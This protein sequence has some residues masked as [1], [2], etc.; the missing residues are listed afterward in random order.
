MAARPAVRKVSADFAGAKAAAE[1]LLSKFGLTEPPVDPV[2]MARQ[3]G[4]KVLFVEF[5]KP[6]QKVSGFYDFEDQSI[7]VN[8]DEHPLRQTFTV[9]HELGHH[10]LHARWAKSSAYKV[11]FRD[12]K[13][14]ALDP[15]EQEANSFAAYLLVP[16]PM[17]DRYR[18]LDPDELSR[19]FVVSGPVIR[20]RINFEYRT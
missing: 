11:L 18:S 13:L 16:R 7:Y 15:Y 4:L 12:S 10:I 2:D 17:L 19:L 8:A 6:M 20:N 9:A 5:E 3:L 1:E 14:G